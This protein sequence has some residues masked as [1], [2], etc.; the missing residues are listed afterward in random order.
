MFAQKSSVSSFVYNHDISNHTNGLFLST[1]HKNNRFITHA[2]ITKTI[3]KPVK[4]PAF[5]D[6]PH[7]CGDTVRL[8]KLQEGTNS[9]HP[10][11]WACREYIDILS[12]S[13]C[14]FPFEIACS[15]HSIV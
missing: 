14:W 5:C 9:R 15:L 11:V 4:F 1:T 12:S 2:Y 7:I 10:N 6:R 3:V 13:R 8:S